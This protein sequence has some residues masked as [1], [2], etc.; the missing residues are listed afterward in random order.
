MKVHFCPNCNNYSRKKKDIYHLKE[1][2]YD[3]CSKPFICDADMAPIIK[4]LNNHGYITKYSCIG[5]ASENY[6]Q[7]YITFATTYDTVAEAAE[8][9][10]LDVEYTKQV[11]VYDEKIDEKYEM[12]IVPGVVQSINGIHEKDPDGNEYIMPIIEDLGMTMTIRFIANGYGE[13]VDMKAIKRH[14]EILTKFILLCEN[15]K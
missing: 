5:H 1:T 13:E 12:F 4:F 11:L 8:K 2:C 14:H 9:A 6:S 10:G 7:A 15:L 3:G